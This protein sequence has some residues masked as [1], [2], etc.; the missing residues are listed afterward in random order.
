MPE[1][2][3]VLCCACNFRKSE[4]PCKKLRIEESWGSLGHS[5]S[6][7]PASSA[8]A[9]RPANKQTALH[10]IELCRKSRKASATRQNSNAFASKTNIEHRHQSLEGILPVQTCIRQIASLP[11]PFGKS[12]VVVHLLGVFN[13]ERHKPKA[14]ALLQYDEPSDPPI[15]VL[16]RMYTLELAMEANDIVD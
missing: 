11:V 4:S 13:N 9:K 6:T 16:K 14:Q 15:A 10:R 12:T 1:R 8:R 5:R 2:G 7:A 3:K